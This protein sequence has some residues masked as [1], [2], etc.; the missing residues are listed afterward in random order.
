MPKHAV[1][2]YGWDPSLDCA[3]AVA[4]VAKDD[5]VK[6]CD[7]IAVGPD[8]VELLEF[9]STATETP[10]KS[11]EKLVGKFVET[12]ALLA[13]ADPS[14]SEWIAATRSVMPTNVAYC[15]IE[16]SATRRPNDQLAVQRPRLRQ[17]LTR[18]LS[19]APEGVNYCIVG[20]NGPSQPGPILVDVT[21][22]AQ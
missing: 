12:R 15:Y 21:R 16:R 11:V 14:G 4:R 2:L 8:A 22:A 20:P 1:K 3:A 9:S 7:A 5:G 19:A 17:A 10:A 6:F 13:F 18:L